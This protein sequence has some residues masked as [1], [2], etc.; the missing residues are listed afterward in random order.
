MLKSECHLEARSMLSFRLAFALLITLAVAGCK[1]QLGDRCQ[2][3]SDCAGNLF[4]VVPQAGSEGVSGGGTCQEAADAS[5][6]D[7][8]SPADTATP[9]DLSTGADMSAGPDL[10][11]AADQSTV[12][13]PDESAGN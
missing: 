5:V 7:S 6:A 2:V 1:Q 8:S 10:V 3:D 13:P 4:C 9:P 12:P 11:T